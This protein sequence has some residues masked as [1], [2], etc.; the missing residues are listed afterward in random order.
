M[1][2]LDLFCSGTTIAPS[3]G[4]NWNKGFVLIKYWF[5]TTLYLITIFFSD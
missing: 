1:M 5:C 2:L 4:I 3:I